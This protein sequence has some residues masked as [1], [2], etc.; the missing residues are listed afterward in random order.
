MTAKN[1]QIF[2]L[3]QEGI[4]RLC[5]IEKSKQFA[6]KRKLLQNSLEKKIQK[7]LYFLIKKK[8]STEFVCNFMP[9]RIF[10]I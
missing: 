6:L 9:N 8:S 10:F 4:V 2:C 5:R 7:F 3:V 1:S